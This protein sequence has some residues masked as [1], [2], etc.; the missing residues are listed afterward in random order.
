[1]TMTL[2]TCPHCG[3]QS[4]V[5]LLGL[6]DKVGSVFRTLFGRGRA[7]VVSFSN[8]E[9]LAQ[10]E[11]GHIEALCT[12]CSKRFRSDRSAGVAPRPTARA[13]SRPMAE[14]IRELEA[15][16]AQ[17]VITPEEYLAQRRRIL[18]EL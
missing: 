5:P 11:A 9:F 10:F 3:A 1:M 6:T 8:A 4:A 16:R 13:A 18:D 14:R 12:R 15:L 17:G 7:G 2:P